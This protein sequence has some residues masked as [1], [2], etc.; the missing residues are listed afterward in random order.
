LVRRVKGPY[1]HVR[2]TCQPVQ[3]YRVHFFTTISAVPYVVAISARQFAASERRQC[4][5]LAPSMGPLNVLTREAG[6]L[7][8]N[9][10]MDLKF[11]AGSLQ[12]RAC[13]NNVDLLARE[14]GDLITEDRDF[15]ARDSIFRAIVHS[16]WALQFQSWWH[17]TLPQRKR[18][19]FLQFFRL[20]QWSYLLVLDQVRLLLH[21]ISLN[22]IIC[23]CS[24]S[25]QNNLNI[26]KR[27]L[28]ISSN[29]W[30]STLTWSSLMG[31]I[32]VC[33]YRVLKLRPSPLPVVPEC[34]PAVFNRALGR[35]ND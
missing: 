29:K 30:H 34:C 15:L 12:R 22:G 6:G 7:V 11:R 25:F 13:R 16:C 3:G 8:R 27:F 1:Y 26:T 20:H 2:L 5:R 9:T 31:A 18:N 24:M 19:W 35:S 10:M 4:R 23:S 17:V 28:R 32:S 33:Q 21:F 14:N